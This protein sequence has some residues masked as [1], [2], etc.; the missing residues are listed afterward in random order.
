MNRLPIATPTRPLASGH[1]MRESGP[2]PY[3]TQCAHGDAATREAEFLRRF[4]TAVRVNPAAGEWFYQARDRYGAGFAP[5]SGRMSSDH[6]LAHLTGAGWIASRAAIGTDGAPIADRVAFDLDLKPEAGDTGERRLAEIHATYWRIRALMGVCRTPLV[7]GSP[8]GGLRI[9]Y[10]ISPRP[11]RELVRGSAHGLVADVLTAAGLV[12]RSGR[13]EIFPQRKQS[14]RLPL[15]RG[16]PILDPE[17]LSPVL[18]SPMR[19]RR[20][21][22]WTRDERWAALEALEQWRARPCDDLVEHLRALRAQSSADAG[23]G[24]GPIVVGRS[25]R[26]D[27]AVDGAGDGLQGVVTEEGCTA[28][29]VPIV[30]GPALDA[31]V[32]RG[33]AV[34]GQRYTTEFRVAMAFVASPERYA[35]FGLSAKSTSN[36]EIALALVEWL[37]RHHNGNSGEWLEAAAGG[38]VDRARSVFLGRYLARDPA[39]RTIV[40]RARDALRWERTGDRPTV[41]PGPE[42]FKALLDVAVKRFPTTARRWGFVTWSLALQHASR[43]KALQSGAVGAAAPDGAITWQIYSVWAKRWPGGSGACRIGDT[44]PV[45]T[46]YAAYLQVLEEARLVEL[47]TP[48]VTPWDARRAL[49]PGIDYRP[50]RSDPSD[51]DRVRGE[52]AMYR[53]RLLGPVV[54]ESALP[55]RPEVLALAARNAPSRHGKIVSVDEVLHAAWAG[56]AKGRVALHYGARQWQHVAVLQEVLRVADRL[57]GVENEPESRIARAA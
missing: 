49:Q 15:G 2:Q 42:A 23:S 17:T 43:L 37:A 11:L 33:V 13:L 53:V 45:Q 44:G 1:A 28:S 39:R 46:A 19:R 32:R 21:G 40:D 57:L 8:G 27:P 20:G 54:H 34:S 38:N 14:D 7:Y 52:C 31:Y 55:Y 4:T 3:Q 36:D 35:E 5:S 29:T 25:D 16:M 47:I 9:S 26:R 56:Q 18:G 30:P 24:D 51:I 12:I 41:Y 6:L 50:P 22:T 10:A 48:H